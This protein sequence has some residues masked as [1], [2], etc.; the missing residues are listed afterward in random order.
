[1]SVALLVGCGT[2][3]NNEKDAAATTS[4][5]NVPGLVE[6]SCLADNLLGFS[7][8]PQTAAPAPEP[9]PIPAD[10]APVRV[11]TCEGDW[12]AGV[13]EHSV[14]W[15][16][17]RREGDMGAVVDTSGR[18]SMPSGSYRSPNGLSTSSP[19]RRRLKLGSSPRSDGI[20]GHT[21]AGAKRRVAD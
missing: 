19:F 11:V 16:E 6:P 3:S 8:L 18:R 1:M 4:R 21:W 10:F 14:S 17:E 15:V 13:V 20:C 7:D 2:P 9:R 5:V 12:N